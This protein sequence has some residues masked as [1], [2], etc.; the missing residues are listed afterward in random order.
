MASAI[1]QAAQDSNAAAL[2]RDK[3]LRIAPICKTQFL[4]C[5]DDELFVGRAGYLCG[6]LWLA[7]ETNT[8]LALNDLYDIC[9]AVIQSGK[10]YAQ[11]HDSKCPLM[12][13]YYKKEYLGA[14]HGICSVLQMLMSVPGYMD[15]FPDE[16][17]DIK[18]SVDYILTLQQEN[19]NFPT[20][21]MCRE[22]VS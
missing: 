4:D 14:A 10:S 18:A 19:G 13:S 11:R 17:Q 5:G 3:Y 8:P 12:Y 9:N 2:Y 1:Y 7:K 16:A 6:A 15:A 21:N 22:D 20:Q